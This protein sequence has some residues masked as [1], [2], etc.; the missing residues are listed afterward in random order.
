MSL[1][2]LGI[3]IGGTFIKYG[4]VDETYT[5]VDK[6]KV[7]ALNFATKD[8]FYD[9]IVAQANSFEHIRHIGISAPGLVDLAGVIRSYAAPNVRIMYGTNA[10]EEVE[11][12]TRKTVAVINDAKA[13]GL[14]E[15]TIGN[16]QHIGSS[17]F[18]IIGTGT[19]GCICVHDQVIFGQDGFAGEFHCL[20]FIDLRDGSLQMQGNYS[21]M[22]ALI[23][24]YN[25]KQ[26]EDRQVTYG[27]EKYL[28]NDPIAHTALEEWI[29][30]ISVHLLMITIFYNPAVICVGGGISEEA[31]FI[32]LV[33]QSYR[34]MCEEYFQGH[35]PLSTKILSCKYTND[36]N[37]LGAVIKAR[38]GQ[39]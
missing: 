32:A 18:L 7:P 4:I 1:Y 33:Q 14:C 21:C 2:D 12:R 13:A 24:S 39:V 3:D 27:T 31:W 17:A 15:V 11:A 16:A 5:V 34:K 28:D 20:P 22:T 8:E 29:V 9:Y 26:P 23:S 35:W 36:A 10:R 38:R 19:G 30:G 25:S 6:W 37:L